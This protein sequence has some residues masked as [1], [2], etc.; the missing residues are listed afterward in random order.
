MK[1][2]FRLP[3]T[4]ALFPIDP[5]PEIDLTTRKSRGVALIIAIMIIS[6][7]M[8]FAS[9]FI[10]SSTVDLTMASSER[11]NVKAEYVAKSGANWALWLNLFDYGI[12]LNFSASKDPA[13]QQ[14][15]SAI[16]P[17]WGKLNDVF[18]FETPLDLSNID[19]FAKAFGMNAFMD[20]KTIEMFKALGGE[21]GV[22]VEDEGGKINLNVC[23]QSKPACKITVMQLDALM[24]CSPVEQD[25]LREKNIKSSEVVAKIQ[26]WIDGDQSVEPNS[27]VS[28]EDDPY[29]RRV[30]PHRAKNSPLDT[31][32]ELKTID[33]WSDELHVYF[34]PYLTVYPFVHS[35]DRE[36]TAYKLNVNS[37][38][39]EVL[40]CIFSRELGNPEAGE[41]FSKK[42]RELIEKNGKLAGSDSEVEGLIRDLIGFKIDPSEKGKEGDKGSWWTTSSRAYSIRAKGVV[43]N[44][45]KIVELF[46]ERQSPAQR[47]IAPT[48]PPWSVDGFKMR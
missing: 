7:M 22:G 6:V 10:V 44:Q 19:T 31:L 17:L 18:P 45:T 8:M 34:A 26:D 38:N 1:C 36:K 30:P 35:Q 39:P 23:Y 4:T 43:G 42:Y 46:M 12:E 16:G 13:M 14:A 25:Y 3:K 15:K 48:S 2:W 37:M 11:D 47:K 33:G 5:D 24:N 21:L 9:D 27:G 28:S 41:N 29:Q 20:S 32:D 40:R